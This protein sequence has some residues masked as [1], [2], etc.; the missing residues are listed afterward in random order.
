MTGFREDSEVFRKHLSLAYHSLDDAWR[1]ALD[2]RHTDIA[3]RI[4]G[5]REKAR[6]LSNELESRAY[7]RE[8]ME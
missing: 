2:R 6:E 1:D 8:E 5:I 3:D 4:W 7:S